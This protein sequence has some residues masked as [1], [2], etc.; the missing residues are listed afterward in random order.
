MFSSPSGH[1]QTTVILLRTGYIATKPPMHVNALAAWFVL[2]NDCH[3]SCAGYLPTH[4]AKRESNTE[5]GTIR[6][7]HGLADPCAAFLIEIK[8]SGCYNETDN[9]T[10][11]LWTEANQNGQRK[12]MG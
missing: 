11:A 9:L 4:G 8:D 1:S 7:A 2:Y 3:I 5:N 6:N 12:H 10:Y